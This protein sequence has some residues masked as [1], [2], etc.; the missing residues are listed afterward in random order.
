MTSQ[1][2]ADRRGERAHGITTLPV[3][4]GP[5]RA[6]QMIAPFLVLPWLILPLGVWLTRPGGLPWLQSAPGPTAALG[7]ILMLLGGSVLPLLSNPEALAQD[8]NHP[9]W[10]RMYGLM[11]VS[12]N[13]LAGC[14][15]AAAP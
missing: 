10:A 1:D 6:A 4:H 3:R 9:I 5:T 8:A 2:F 13:G 14:Y 7:M 12:Q 11:M 15:L